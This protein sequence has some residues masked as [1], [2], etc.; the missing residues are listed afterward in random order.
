M[1][2]TQMRAW[3]RP[4]WYLLLAPDTTLICLFHMCHHKCITVTSVF[5]YHLTRENKY[6]LWARQR[7][8]EYGGDTKSMIYR[9]TL[10]VCDLVGLT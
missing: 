3:K 1:S 10:V 7:T 9:V 5:S 2:V 6:I 8:I 4:S